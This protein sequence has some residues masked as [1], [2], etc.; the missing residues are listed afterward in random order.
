[1]L[2]P[3]KQMLL[4]MFLAFTFTMKLDPTSNTKNLKFNPELMLKSVNAIK[5]ARD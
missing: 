3:A 1:M 5:F 2:I 4:K